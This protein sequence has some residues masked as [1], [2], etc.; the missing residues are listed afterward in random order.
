MKGTLQS[1]RKYKT[2]YV[3]DEQ[4]LDDAIGLELV[5]LRTD[6]EGKDHIYAVEPLKVVKRDGNLFTFEGYNSIM[7]AGCFKVAYRMYPKNELLPHR[8]DFCFVKWI[9]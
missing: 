7:N 3:I 5:V 2:T 9:E 6:N 8:Q 4:G 1:G